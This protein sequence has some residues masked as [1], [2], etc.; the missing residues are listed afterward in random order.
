VTQYL[1]ERNTEQNL[2]GGVVSLRRFAEHASAGLYDWPHWIASAHSNGLSKPY[3]PATKP[4]IELQS[5]LLEFEESISREASLRPQE[6]GQR[7]G[8]QLL[9]I[10]QLCQELGMGK[11]WVYRRL[12]SGEIPSVRQGRSIGA[13]REELEGY[14][15]RHRYPAR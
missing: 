12:G 6:E 10:P 15:Q 3:K 9:S 4:S 13:R 2:H 11:S 1:S 8:G 14:L 5:A 7:G